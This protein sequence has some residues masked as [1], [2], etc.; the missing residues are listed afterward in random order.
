VATVEID[1]DSRD[2]EQV[3][4]AVQAA[5]GAVAPEPSP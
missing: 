2:P 3:A 5:L 1:T 4:D